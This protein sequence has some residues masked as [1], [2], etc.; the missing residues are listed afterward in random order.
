MTQVIHFSNTAGC[1]SLDTEQKS[2]TLKLMICWSQVA[3]W[4][5]KEHEARVARGPMLTLAQMCHK[6]LSQ[7]WFVGSQRSRYSQVNLT[8]QIMN[9]K[10][11]MNEGLLRS[12]EC[13]MPVLLFAGAFWRAAAGAR[14]LPSALEKR[15]S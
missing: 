9:L 13:S 15:G 10:E 2:N 3:Q 14:K 1:C 6:S 7:F 11:Q 5:Q 12:Q 8:E 4:S